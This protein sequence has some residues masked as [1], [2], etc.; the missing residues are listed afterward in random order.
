MSVGVVH[1]A[2][3]GKEYYDLNPAV[4][5]IWVKHA[6][7]GL[8]YVT[9]FLK[10]LPK[11]WREEME[12]LLKSMYVKP[13]H[14]SAIQTKLPSGWD[15]VVKRVVATP[16]GAILDLGSTSPILG[17]KVSA[18]TR[19][20]AQMCVVCG[21]DGATTDKGELPRCNYHKFDGEV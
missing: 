8:I 20:T 7:I 11:G 2:T 19:K 5:G 18:F 15:G 17:I 9:H 16:Y 10:I 13:P 21:C 6:T 4:S 1:L 14:D 12:E 3:G